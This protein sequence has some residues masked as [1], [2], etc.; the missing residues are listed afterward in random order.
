MTDS[1]PGYWI[2]VVLHED[3]IGGR[4]LCDESGYK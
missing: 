3:E 2:D 4:Y 1:V